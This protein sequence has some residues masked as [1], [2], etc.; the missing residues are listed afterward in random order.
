MLVY[1]AVPTTQPM[2]C[3][4]EDRGGR[5]NCSAKRYWLYCVDSMA[6]SWRFLVAFFSGDVCQKWRFFVVGGLIFSKSVW[7]SEGQRRWDLVLVGWR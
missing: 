5:G 6:G 1:D 2:G 7:K 3:H 4:F